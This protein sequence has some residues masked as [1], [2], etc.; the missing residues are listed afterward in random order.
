MHLL[1]WEGLIKCSMRIKST[2]TE[3]ALLPVMSWF[4][5]KSF[6]KKCE[7]PNL[8]KKKK[9]N[10]TNFLLFCSLYSTDG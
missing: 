5:L 6:H 7:N 9:K 10:I 8:K 1:S 2:L 4:K 3:K